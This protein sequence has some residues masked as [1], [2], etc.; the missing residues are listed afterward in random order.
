MGFEGSC[1]L[2]APYVVWKVIESNKY[3]SHLGHLKVEIDKKCLEL[4]KRKENFTRI[5]LDHMVARTKFFQYDWKV[6]ILLPYQIL[7]FWT[8]IYF[9]LYGFQLMKTNKK[10]I[11][12]KIAV[13]CYER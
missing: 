11:P 6:F 10:N 5:M 3:Y 2:W 4:V 1:L 8:I 13:L 9:G 7:Y 12:W